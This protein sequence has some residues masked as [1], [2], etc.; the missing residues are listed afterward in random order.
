VAGLALTVYLGLGLTNVI[1]KAPW[2]DEAWFGNPAYNLA[3]RGFMGTTVLDPGSS[4]W[5]NVKLTGIDR[6]TYWVMPLNLLFN[7]AGFRVFGFRILVM[8]V[9]SLAWGLIA[10]IAWAIVLWKLTKNRALALGTTAL[11]AID[12]HFLAQAGD[13]RMDVM[14]VALGWSGVAAYLTLRD[15][16]FTWALAASQTLT[17]LALFTH[18]NGII[19]VLILAVTTL[20]LDAKRLRIPH[21]ALALAPYFALAAGWCVYI[22]QRPGD[23]VAQFLGNA[24][25]RGPVITTPLA[26]LHSEITNRYLANYGMASW[27]SVTGRLNAIPLLMFLAGVIACLTIPAIRRDRG[28][29]LLLIWA[30]MAAGI[31]AELEGLKTPFYLIYVTPLYTALMWTATVW[32]WSQR[33]RWRIPLAGALCLFC[34]LQV[35]RTLIADSRHPRQSTFDPAVEYLRGQFN[36]KTFIMGGAQLLFGLG[37]DWNVLDDVR[38]GYNTGKRPDV[39]VI[40]PGWEDRI[41]A[42]RREAPPIHAFVANLLVTDYHEVYSRE[43][44]RILLRNGAAL[45]RRNQAA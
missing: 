23:F 39:V 7:A 42:L 3:F 16:N 36:P 25:G 17:A 44:Y 38:L 20:S 35:S 28:Y 21:L 41:E 40:D 6:H 30:A 43:G 24:S 12:Y 15:W 34:L 13:G 32:L 31:L 19:L 45:A 10:L 22:L 27:A 26:A 18:P 11:T 14:T 8:R 4:T 5:K 33:M 2:C 1:T 37:P 9:F 29:R